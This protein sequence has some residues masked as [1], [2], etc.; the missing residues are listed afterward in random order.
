MTLEALTE[1]TMNQEAQIAKNA[2]DI[3][4]IFHQLDNH[5]ER[6]VENSKTINA[7]HDLALSVRELT[8]KVDD[9][10][11]R[12]KSI[13]EEKKQ[14]THAIWQIIV[15][16]VIGGGLTLLVTQLVTGVLGG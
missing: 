8:G 3:S 5:N 7:I 14:R 9:V 2:A 1:K 10:D 16:A 4:T 12:V 11:K 6:I 13:E 15:S